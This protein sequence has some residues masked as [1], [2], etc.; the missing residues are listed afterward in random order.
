MTF[1]Q[2]LAEIEIYDTR[3]DRL[4]EDFEILNKASY[5]KLILWLEAAWIIGYNHAMDKYLDDGK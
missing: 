4:A 5:S 3:E 2:W 1:E